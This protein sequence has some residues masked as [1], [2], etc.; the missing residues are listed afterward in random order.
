MK[1]YWKKLWKIPIH[2]QLR[3]FLWKCILDI[4]P[5]GARL[6]RK[7]LPVEA[8]CLICRGKNEFVMH[9]IAECPFVVVVWFAS[10]L[11][12]DNLSLDQS[13]F[14]LLFKR[15]QHLL[16]GVC[17]R[18]EKRHILKLG[19]V[20]RAEQFKEAN[21][22]ILAAGAESDVLTN[23]QEIWWQAPR[24]GWFKK[25]FDGAWVKQTSTGGFG[26]LV[27]TI[28]SFFGNTS[29][30]EWFGLTQNNIHGRIPTE[31]GQL[32][33]LQT[34][35]LSSNNLTGNFSNVLSVLDLSMNNF[36]GSIPTSFAKGNKLR[37]IDLNG[38]QLE[39]KVPQSLATCRHLEVLDFG[40]NNINDT[41]PY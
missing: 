25:N 12:L 35:Y 34:F 18:V 41:F 39:G 19:A 27:G 21:L 24:G 1:S 31:L 29:S 5:V 22:P 16:F 15:W 10:P 17:G 28:P 6:R 13:F 7:K 33:N 14:L 40:N 32:P 38:N 3:L 20:L 37:T 8:T 4:V 30:L 2:G 11:R 9:M 23:G 26:V 36:Y